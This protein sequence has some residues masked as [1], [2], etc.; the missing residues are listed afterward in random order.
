MNNEIFANTQQ[1]NELIK[2]LSPEA[3]TLLIYMQLNEWE[4]I[5]YR[6]VDTLWCYANEL[7]DF[8]YIEFVPERDLFLIKK[9]IKCLQ[10]RGPAC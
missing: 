6:Y 7:I 4:L 3:L 9:P 5:N 8:G 2:T 10:V 1:V